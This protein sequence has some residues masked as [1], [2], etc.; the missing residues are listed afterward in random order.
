M[1]QYIKNIVSN[2]AIDKNWL[3]L[4]TLK[5]QKKIRCSDSKGYS[6]IRSLEQGVLKPYIELNPLN[7][8]EWIIIDVDHENT[9]YKDLPICPN[10]I[11]LNKDNNKAHY[12]FKIKAVHNNNLSSFKAIEYYHSI[13]LALTI[14]LN[15]DINF[16][17]K[18]SKNPLASNYFRVLNIHTLEYELSELAEY[19]NL[20]PTY[21]IKALETVT[22]KAD[23]IGR[24]Q[25]IF[26][27]V[28]VEAYKLPITKDIFDKIFNLCHNLNNK[29]KEPLLLQEIKHI[30]KSITKY[31]TSS[32]NTFANFRQKQR[33]KGLKSGE[34][35]RI[36]SERNKAKVIPLFYTNKTL[37]SIAELVGF[38]LR[39]IKSIKAEFKKSLVRKAS[40]LRCNKPIQVVPACGVFSCELFKVTLKH[41]EQIDLFTQTYTKQHL[42]CLE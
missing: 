17:Q 29:L 25:T 14:L 23:I 28:R 2:N 15:G 18:L 20:Q 26:D 33:E 32:K 16:T 42:K 40:S 11:V 19:C 39:T 41:E 24:N 30:A 6:I 10:I 3:V 22:E 35:R 4:D 8:Y 9:Y 12:Y 31:I 38:S 13:R 5:K 27:M 21:K 7:S 1:S 34:I 36:K 37:R